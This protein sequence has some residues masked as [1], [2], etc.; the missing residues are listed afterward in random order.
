MRSEETGPATAAC[1][2]PSPLGET[3][4]SVPRP[5]GASL[6]TRWPRHAR[7]VS[8]A[9]GA[10]RRELVA[11]E[12]QN[13][14]EAAELVLSE[15]L[16]NALRHARGPGDAYV[17]TRFT[18]LPTG[19]RIEVLDPDET[20]PVIRTPSRDD[21][22]GRGLALVDAITGGRWGV[23][24]RDGGGKCVWAEVADSGPG[25]A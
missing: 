4:T 1:H 14:S 22:G 3:T 15:V 5:S 16:T 24:A 21:E 23:A 20:P 7:S 2:V 18:R 25:P 11:W 6:V 9:R 8:L 10:L 12:L 17:E 13:V 19:V